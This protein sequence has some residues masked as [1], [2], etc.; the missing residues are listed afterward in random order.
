MS[1]GLGLLGGKL[2]AAADRLGGGKVDEEGEDPHLGAAERAQERID[3][4]DPV[5][6]LR[7]AEPS[8]P[9][10]FVGVALLARHGSA[11]CSRRGLAALAASRVGIKAPVAHRLL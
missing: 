7:P 3:L 1:Q 2:E 5:D 4:V 10:G 9:G 8:S 6:Q 11:V